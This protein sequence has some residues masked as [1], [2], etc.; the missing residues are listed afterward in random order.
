MFG[1]PDSEPGLVIR[2]TVSSRCECQTRLFA[3]LD[4]DCHVVRGWAL[5]PSSH[6]PEPAPA[7]SLGVDDG[8]FQ[9]G[10]FCPFCIR[11]VLR[12]YSEPSLLWWSELNQTT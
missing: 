9:V 7:L 4:G 5:T 12:S 6:H 3:E 1:P 2:A 10:W 8:E 11:N